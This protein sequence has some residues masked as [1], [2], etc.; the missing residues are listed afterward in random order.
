MRINL[1]NQNDL[2]GPSKVKETRPIP[3]CMLGKFIIII[4]ILFKNF[5]LMSMQEPLA[6]CA[7]SPH[8]KKKKIQFYYKEEIPVYCQFVMLNSYNDVFL[9]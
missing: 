3:T 2:R 1:Q 4:I 7:S 9:L 6:L 5:K 8:Q